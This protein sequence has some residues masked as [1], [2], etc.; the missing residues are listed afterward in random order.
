MTEERFSFFHGNFSIFFRIYFQRNEDDNNNLN[1][2][3]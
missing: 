3:H 2:R 1:L